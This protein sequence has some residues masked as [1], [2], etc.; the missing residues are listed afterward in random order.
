MS[1][2]S[3][4]FTIPPVLFD[5]RGLHGKRPGSPTEKRRALAKHLLSFIQREEKVTRDREVINWLTKA[6]EKNTLVEVVWYLKQ[7]PESPVSTVGRGR[8]PIWG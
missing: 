4:P 1:T 2:Q 6:V 3:D 7:L 8:D 5:F